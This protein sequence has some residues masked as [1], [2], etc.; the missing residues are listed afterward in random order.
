MLSSTSGFTP[1]GSGSH[2]TGWHRTSGTH[3]PP[4]GHSH[5]RLLGYSWPPR[6]GPTLRLPTRAESAAATRPSVR[7]FERYMKL[8]HET[9][10]CRD[11][12]GM[13]IFFFAGLRPAPR[14]GYRPGPE[15]W[16]THT[17]RAGR[18]VGL[19]TRGVGCSHLGGL[20]QVGLQCEAPGEPLPPPGATCSLT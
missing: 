13:L 2:I 3:T 17:T 7:F 19:H 10:D 16:G 4:L 15:G 8:R 6:S 5:R 14:Q 20:P 12:F 18:G 11:C 9:V 1:D